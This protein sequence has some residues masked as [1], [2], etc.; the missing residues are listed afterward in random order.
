MPQY[1]LLGT[2]QLVIRSEAEA[3]H[4]LQA[5]NREE[6]YAAQ[7][8]LHAQ[9]AECAQA[10]SHRIREYEQRRSEEFNVEFVYAEAKTSR[11]C[12]E[13]AQAL[14][15][16]EMRRKTSEFKQAIQVTLADAP[17]L[18]QEQAA[19][20]ADAVARVEATHART[21]DMMAV[22]DRLLHGEN[23]DLNQQMKYHDFREE[24]TK[25][26][27]VSDAREDSPELLPE[28]MKSARSQKRAF[29]TT[30]G[31]ENEYTPS[32][33]PP[34]VREALKSNAR[35]PRGSAEIPS[36]RVR[37]PPK[38]SAPG[39]PLRWGWPRC[40]PRTGSLRQNADEVCERSQG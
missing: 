33:M 17:Q 40:Q 9:Y 27:G 13:T 15:E 22:Q 1:L 12:E 29:V 30:D 24:G 35:G 19:K 21:V 16:A 6:L 5:E 23:D 38:T 25:H 10:Q 7:N 32:I 8:Q 31:Y 34:A 20:H 28:E 2:M 26:K 4:H 37:S 14:H 3:P 39:P 11:T 18:L 36:G